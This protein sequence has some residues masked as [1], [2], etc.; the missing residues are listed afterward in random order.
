MATD[1][2]VSCLASTPRG[3]QHGF[4]FRALDTTERYFAFEQLEAEAQRR[5]SQLQALD[6]KQGD[7]LALVIADPAEFVLS[8]ASATV[9]PVRSP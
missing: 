2:L 4:R 6:L 8:F 7:R 9:A 1:T 5:A 3:T